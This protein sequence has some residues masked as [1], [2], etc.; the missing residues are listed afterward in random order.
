M[1]RIFEVSWKK[2][3]NST[4]TI[5]AS[6]ATLSQRIEQDVEQPLRSFTSN[7]REMSGIATIQGN[8]GN[9]AKELED[10]QD[11][12]EKLGKKGGKASTQKMES[13]ASK[14]Q[15]ATQQWEAQS[16]FVFEKL[17]ALDESRL[18]HL[19]DVLTQYE[20]HEADQIERNRVTVEQTLRSL[21]EIDSSQ[22]I[23]NWAQTAVARR[24]VTERTS[25]QLSNA[26]SGSFG[27]SFSAGLGANPL[28]QTP[29]SAHTDNASEHSGKHEGEKSGKFF[30]SLKAAAAAFQAAP[31]TSLLKCSRVQIR[32]ESFWDNA[33]AQTP[34]YSW[35]LQSSPI[36]I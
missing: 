22:E 8:L 35:W 17:Q 6:H 19:R 3:I 29:R 9:M 7:N 10:A 13:A 26:G 2:I 12:S 5:A 18:N 11:K 33:R 32:K 34:K 4:E 23:R 16:P 20:T 25:R 31:S 30:S 27:G 1:L 28:P 21:L 36:T 24:P 15:T 14:L